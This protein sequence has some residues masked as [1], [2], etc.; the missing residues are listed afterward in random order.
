MPNG[1]ICAFRPAYSVIPP[2]TSTSRFEDGNLP[3]RLLTSPPKISP[4]K[5]SSSTIPE[6]IVDSSLPSSGS[7]W[8]WEN[9]PHSCVFGAWTNHRMRTVMIR[10]DGFGC[11]S[12]VEFTYRTLSR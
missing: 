10:N 4:P 12:L 9:R 3:K 8:V 5:I 11:D 1:F 7:G 2:R 6:I